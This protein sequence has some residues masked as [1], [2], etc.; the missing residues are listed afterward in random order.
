LTSVL[1]RGKWSAPA[2]LFP[3]KE[4]SVPIARLGLR[5]NLDDMER[6]KFLPLPGLE[7]GTLSRPVDSAV[8]IP[9][10]LSRLSGGSMYVRK[11]GN[12]EDHNV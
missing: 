12:P 2:A 4:P 9:T 11:V 5:A 3:G 10:A 6:K 1:D 7:L 8:A